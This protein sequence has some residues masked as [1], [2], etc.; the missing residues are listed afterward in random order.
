MLENQA[1]IASRSYEN[2]SEIAN[3][4]VNDN[5]RYFMK[6]ATDMSRELEHDRNTAQLGLDTDMNSALFSK[7]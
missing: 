6:L 7:D 1:S 5:Y 2:P 4:F 3:I